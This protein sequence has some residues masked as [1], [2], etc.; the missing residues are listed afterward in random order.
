MIRL[1]LDERDAWVLTE[2]LSR[3]I[4]QNDFYST[5]EDNNEDQFDPQLK[6]EII[7]LYDELLKLRGF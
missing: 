2:A 7:S 3:V 4:E 5:D 6:E 1:E